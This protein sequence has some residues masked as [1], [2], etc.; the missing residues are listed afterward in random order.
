MW[1]IPLG[2]GLIVGHLVDPGPEKEQLKVQALVPDPPELCSLT[3]SLWSPCFLIC[4][5]RVICSLLLAGQALN[6]PKVLGK[7]EKQPPKERAG[8]FRMIHIWV[9][10]LWRV[11]TTVPSSLGKTKISEASGEHSGF[12]VTEKIC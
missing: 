5:I 3:N 1:L 2:V 4:E 9:D 8:L 6:S 10:S 12:A 7:V 11:P